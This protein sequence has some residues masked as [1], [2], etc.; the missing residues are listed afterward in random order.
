MVCNQLKNRYIIK[1]LLK[2]IIKQEREVIEDDE[3]EILP[4]L[5]FANA[6]GLVKESQCEKM[7]EDLGNMIEKNIDLDVAIDKFI[8]AY[9][10]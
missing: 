9:N 1:L 4:F 2:T 7:Y 8:S 6:L 10:I 5:D 3:K